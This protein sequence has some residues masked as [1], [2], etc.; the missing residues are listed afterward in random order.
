M[1]AA[2]LYMAL[3]AATFPGVSP[4]LSMDFIGDT[5][6]LVALLGLTT[7]F[8]GLAVCGLVKI[9][10]GLSRKRLRLLVVVLYPLLP[11]EVYGL[12]G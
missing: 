12:I 4:S 9:W 5:D 8:P 7:E 1:A 10:W 2:S 3:E 11:C 6:L